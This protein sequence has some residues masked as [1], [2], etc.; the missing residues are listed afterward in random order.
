MTKGKSISTAISIIHDHITMTPQATDKPLAST[1]I[2]EEIRTSFD[3][4]TDKMSH[5]SFSSRDLKFIDHQHTTSND[6]N[7]L[8]VGSA[9]LRHTDEIRGKVNK[10]FEPEET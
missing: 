7:E 3:L 6:Q 10:G 1:P 5:I 4:G 2:P 8:E 9:W